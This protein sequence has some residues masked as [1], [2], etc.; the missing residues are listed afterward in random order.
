LSSPATAIASPE[1]S[2]PAPPLRNLVSTKLY[3]PRPRAS[4]VARPDLIE[5]LNSEPNHRLTVVSAPAG[6]GKSTLVAQWLAQLSIQSTWASL[7]AG[8][9]TPRA[10]LSL[11]VTALQNIDEGLVA[12][13]QAKLTG[14][15][16]LDV[17]SIVRQLIEE[18][19]ATTRPFILVLDDYH[20][21]A[22]SEIHQSMDLLLQN[23]PMMMQLVLISRTAP[24]LHLAR[25]RAG[26]EVCELGLN[27]LSFSQ[28]E[29]LQFFHTSLNLDLAPSEVE[30]LHR[31]TE[32]WVAG[33][34][35]AG[36]ALRGQPRDRL[37]RYVEEF[38][39]NS[40]F[41]N[42]YLWE[43]VLQ[44]QPEDVRSFLLSTSV[45]DRFNAELC[46]AVNAS[47]GS[48]EL[49]RRCRRDNLFVLPL[50]D[51]SSWH[52]YH[53]LFAEVLRDRLTQSTSDA[54]I[55]SLHGRASVWLEANGFLEDAVRHA[56]A[57]RVW[58]DAIRLLEV[59][60]AALFERDHV[61][62]L[63]AWLEGLPPEILERSPRLTFWLA[64]SLGRT[65]R[66]NEGSRLL[67]VSGEAWTA[68]NDWLGQ[69]L[70]LLWHACRVLYSLENRKAIEYAQR[71]LDVLPEDRPAE[72]VIALMTQGI[73]HL[74]RGDPIRAEHAFADVRVIVDTRSLPWLQ[75]F[76]TSYSAAVLV[77]QGKLRESTVLSRQ[78]IRATGEMPSEIWVQKA[79]LELGLVQYEWD[80]L[81]DAHRT[82][83]RAD[84]L[85]EATRALQWR[86]RIRTGLARIA[87]ARGDFEDA[88]DEI[89]QAISFANQL[90]TLQ[91]VRSARAL[92]AR[93]WIASHQLGLA[94]RWSESCELDPYLPPEYERQAEH[95]TYV[96]LLILEDHWKRA[97][98]M[99]GAI[100]SEVEA[101]ERRGELV[102]IYTLTAL[103]HKAAGQIPEAL[104]SL[105]NA[106]ELGESSGYCRVFVEEG[107]ELA[108]LLRHA[109][110][111][112]NF[113]E[114]ASRL[115]AAI[116]GTAIV[117]QLDQRATPDTLSEREIEVL[118]LVAA[119]MANR[120]IGQRLFISEKTVKT[121][122][123]H[124]LGKL[125]ATN[126]TQAVDQARRLGVI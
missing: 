7:D 85:A 65:G 71:A 76:E 80:M 28:A 109:T 29:A 47:E 1:I 24:P 108:F 115:L 26:G 43:E 64:W 96:R 83:R 2:I 121:H 72:R 67:R 63:R 60:G 30:L 113:R 27:D 21:I 22:E 107:D 42:Q 54:E 106:L 34:Y 89:E 79:L 37:G 86:A 20:S 93:F 40:Q 32:G 66:W 73:A 52:R 119:G 111:R 74:Y 116:E 56:I 6:Y 59:L 77:Q 62:T 81:D 5:L 19:S 15:G 123:S 12:G 92:Q 25:L 88:L 48:E 90:G 104:Q 3:P 9:N 103:A 17:E 8:D 35:L 23:L 16:P 125:E 39:G 91:E 49:I 31:R 44:N 102:E 117:Q 110:G 14:P 114:Y 46:D 10:F 61:V 118:R 75:G 97:L 98:E 126:R 78:V 41:G 13:T 82:L 69:G 11:I 120:D 84:E 58:D 51:D 55:E 100:Q 53:H 38:A 95:L 122:L 87:W 99:L 33:L 57:G 18:L 68:T 45:L 4:L 94:R 124:I 50:D 101:S 105:R 70:L 36:F 112:G